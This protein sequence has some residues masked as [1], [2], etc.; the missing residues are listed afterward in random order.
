MKSFNFRCVLLI[1]SLDDTTV[2]LY[3][4]DKVKHDIRFVRV[5]FL[6][7]V[8]FWLMSVVCPFPTEA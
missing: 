5:E 6:V 2:A 7:V 1:K 8:E 3:P 4:T